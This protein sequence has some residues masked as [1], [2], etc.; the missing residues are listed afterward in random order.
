MTRKKT[1]NT[2]YEFLEFNQ[3]EFN[4]NYF[5]FYH[6]RYLFK[7]L[8][9]GHGNLY[10]AYNVIGEN[11]NVIVV[12]A[13]EVYYIYSTSYD[14][15]T[16]EIIGES[17]NL[18]D[19]Q[20][21]V[22]KGDNHLITDLLQHANQLFEVLNDR[23]IYS[24]STKIDVNEDSKGDFVVCQNQH[25]DETI[26]L[27]IDYYNEDFQGRG[28]Q[29]N[30]QISFSTQSSLR[31]RQVFGLEVNQQLVSIAKIINNNPEKAMIGGVYTRPEYRRNG[32]GSRLMTL[33]TN[34]LLDSGY[35]ECGLLTERTN[36]ASNK[37]F[38]KS[39]YVSTYEWINLRIT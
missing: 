26:R 19:N 28:Q 35:K 39:G 13:N 24:T 18:A 32:Y 17:M 33:L 4:S 16:I 14:P 27:S 6:L 3:E 1:Y 29:T 12:W 15:E 5:K 7:A 11:F 30:E 23:I 2:P 31:E 37:T 36:E 8:E 10:D 34:H 25:R 9:E 22:F 38:H 20:I 21:L